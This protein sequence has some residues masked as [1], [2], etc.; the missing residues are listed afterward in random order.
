MGRFDAGGA[1][2]LINR[3]EYW[4]CGYSIDKGSFEAIQQDGLENFLL[5]IAEVAPFQD[6]RL[7]TIVSWQQVK[8]LSIRIDRLDQL[9]SDILTMVD[10]LCQRIE[11]HRYDRSNLEGRSRHG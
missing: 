11:R 5:Q 2:V 10:R 9:H 6:H 8:L 1:F 3:R 4:Q 7:Q